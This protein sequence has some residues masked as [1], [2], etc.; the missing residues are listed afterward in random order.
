M[1]SSSRLAC[2][3]AWFFLAAGNAACAHGVVDDDGAFADEASSGT[4]RGEASGDAASAT[5]S[6]LTAGSPGDAPGNAGPDADAGSGPSVILPDPA[7][8]LL[9]LGDDADG[10]AA[11]ASGPSGAA[12]GDGD[13]DGSAGDS[14]AEAPSPGDLAITEVMLSPSEP[15]PYSEWFEIFNLAST[16]RSLNGLTIEDGYGDTALIASDS[17]LALAPGAYGLLV[18]DAQAAAAIALPASAIVYA[19]GEGLS[20]DEGIELDTG[21]FGDLS[22]WNGST[23]LVDVPYGDWEASF[24]GQSLELASPGASEGDPN[25]WCIAETPWAAGSDDGTPG[26]PSDCGSP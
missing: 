7:P 18:R 14:P 6:A 5:T 24:V 2:V 21:D 19:Y 12:P 15:K 23:L 16:P 3:F 10:S 13:T 22:L 8:T 4:A 11:D 20:R 26:A 17:T 1:V 9:L 25:S